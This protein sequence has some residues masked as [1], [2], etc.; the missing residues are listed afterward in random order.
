MRYS[1]DFELF[2]VDGALD[3][4]EL[5]RKRFRQIVEKRVWL[6]RLAIYS[7]YRSEGRR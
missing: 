6:T 1:G 4:A 5:A 7:W 2:V 3:Q